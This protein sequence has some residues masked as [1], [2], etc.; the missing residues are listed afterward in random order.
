[1][2]SIE[3]RKAGVGRI[4]FCAAAMWLIVNAAL[5]YPSYQDFRHKMTIA[6]IAVA[7]DDNPK[8][9]FGIEGFDDASE[10]SQTQIRI[11]QYLKDGKASGVQQGMELLHAL[12]YSAH[13]Y[14]TLQ[15]QLAEHIFWNMNV[16]GIFFA[17][18]SFLLIRRRYA[19][20]RQREAV[21]GMVCGQIEAVRREAAVHFAAEEPDKDGRELCFCEEDVLQE[22]LAM[23]ADHMKLLRESAHRDREETKSLVTD[24]SHQLRT[25]LMALRASFDLLSSGK[26]KEDEYKEFLSCCREQLGRLM[27]LTD[28]LLQISRLETG[29]IVLHPQQSPLF[30]TILTAVNRI[31]PRAQ[32]KNIDIIFEEPYETDA[33][34][35]LWHDERWLSEALI[36]IL[37]NAV[38]Y[39]DCDSE[40]RISLCRMAACMRIEIED[41]G[42]GISSQERNQIF[43]RFWRGQDERVQSQ[44]GQGIGLYLSRQIIEKH[45]GTIRVAAAIPK[46]SRFIVSLPFK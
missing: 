14:G 10:N 28:A 11:T 9:R 1:M 37:E 5:L 20:K 43:K 8:D 18:S 24:I 40:I 19:E 42:I 38:K 15:K 32:E 13:F 25:P 26:L 6:A 23:L 30:D 31:Y 3:K 33:D 7:E 17:V 27:E 29:L 34:L 16:T 44:K 12:G 36:N 41:H 2:G 46:G 39:S 45:H 35:T 21:V 22:E 4:V